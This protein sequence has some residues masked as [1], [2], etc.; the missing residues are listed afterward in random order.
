MCARAIYCI[1]IHLCEGLLLLM[2]LGCRAA[3]PQKHVPKA[4]PKTQVDNVKEIIHGVEV[5]DPYRW[6]EDRESPETEQWIENQSK[7]AE[8]IIGSLPGRQRGSKGAADEVDE[9]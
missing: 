3:W 2:M 6:L 7:Y 8:A 5:S 9:G 4:P 1:S